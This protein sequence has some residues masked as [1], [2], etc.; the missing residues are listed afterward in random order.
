MT[1]KLLTPEEVAQRFQIPRSHVYRMARDGRLPCVSLGRYR[2]FRAEV[3][4]QW[5]RDGGVKEAA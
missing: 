5:E 1:G 3:I 2:R 4:E